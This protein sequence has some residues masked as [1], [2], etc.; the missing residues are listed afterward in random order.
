MKLKY[1]RYKD[2]GYNGFVRS[3]TYYTITF[4]LPRKK[5]LTIR[6]LNNKKALTLPGHDLI[7]DMNLYNGKAE[8]SISSSGG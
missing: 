7:R 4:T 2:G 5:F 8:L 6:N 1:P 3:F